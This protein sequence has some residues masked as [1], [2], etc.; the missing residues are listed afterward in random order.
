MSTHNPYQMLLITLPPYA[1]ALLLLVATVVSLALLLGQV[2]TYARTNERQKAGERVLA[3]TVITDCGLL[4]GV[5]FATLKLPVP[6]S[7]GSQA[8][9]L[10]WI[11]AWGYGLLS[12]SMATLLFTSSTVIF[13][14]FVWSFRDI[15]T[16]LHSGLFGRNSLDKSESN[17][18]GEQ[19]PRDFFVAYRARTGYFED[20]EGLTELLERVTE[21]GWYH[22][23]SEEDIPDVWMRL[24]DG[25]YLSLQV[26][27]TPHG[28]GRSC[29]QDTWKIVRPDNGD[30]VIDGLV[31]EYGP[32][33]PWLP[34]GL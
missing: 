23:V 34:R 13:A 1:F 2:R 26:S 24:P 32:E 14:L 7:I 4:I 17:I 18:K 9:T 11:S 6:P 3:V 10:D 5:L 12:T 21:W 22:D 25:S 19:G 28:D 16:K 15:S 27:R 29:A 30:A 33:N 20:R 31:T 8:G